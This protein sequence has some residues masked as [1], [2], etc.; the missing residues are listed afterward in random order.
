MKFWKIILAAVVIFGAGFVTGGLS[1]KLSRFGDVPAPP[2][3]PSGGG[4]PRMPMGPDRQMADLMRRMESGLDLTEEQKAKIKQIV[5]ES[6]ARMR[7]SWKEMAPRM[8]KEF[9]TLT[10]QIREV[11][12][13]EQ[14]E[15]FEEL[16]RRRS[17]R[18]RSDGNRRGDPGDR[19]GPGRWPERGERRELHKAPSEP[20]EERTKGKDH[21]PRPP[22]S[23]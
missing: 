1:V 22:E 15:K 19:P 2:H 3:R 8:R 14:R 16:T 10:D 17:H 20:S 12:N 9:T 4:G 21:L 18:P 13:P 7:A 6:Q 23:P 5:E 11:L